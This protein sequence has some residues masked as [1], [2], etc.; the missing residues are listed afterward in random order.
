MR[1]L[2]I[3]YIVNGKVIVANTKT[4]PE[5][6]HAFASDLMSDVLTI[7]QPTGIVLLTGL[8]NVQTIRTVEMA[9]FHLVVLLR[10][11]RATSEMQEI[12]WDNEITIIETNYS[13]FRSSAL[14]YNAGIKP[15]F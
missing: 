7:K 4:I 8:A 11:K 1:I 6:T 3:A 2:E 14:L 13:A 10:G 12:A 5:I 9:G 15:L